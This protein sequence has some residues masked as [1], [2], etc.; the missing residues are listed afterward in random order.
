MGSSNKIKIL[1]FLFTL[2]LIVLMFPKG[3][4]L[5]S[6]VAIGSIW[7]KPDLIASKSFEIL[8][9]PKVYEAQKQ[10]AAA[11]VYP[12]FVK[13]KDARKKCL[14]NLDN[15]FETLKTLVAVTKDSSD[16][17]R[18][19]VSRNTF[20]FL[21]KLSKNHTLLSDKK[22]TFPKFKSYVKQMLSSVCRKGILNL[23]YSQ[24]RYDTISIRDDKFLTDYP[25]DNFFDMNQAKTY[26]L[27]RFDKVFSSDSLAAKAAAEI[28][29]K[30]LTPTLRYS[31]IYTS[32]ARQAAM[33]KVPRNL[34]IVNENERIVAKH[35]RITREIKLKIDSYKRY[36]GEEVTLLD[37]FLEY[38]G[39]TLHVA[40]IL[41]LYILYLYLSRKR[42]YENNKYLLLIAIIILVT[43][44]TAYLIQ[45]INVTAPI[46]YLVLVPLGSMLLAILF[47]SRVAFFGTVAIAMLVGGLRGNDYIL[48]LS[49]IAAGGLA[50]YSVRSIRNR[51][52]I[53]RTF[54]YILFGYLAAIFAFGFER[55]LDIREILIEATFASTNALISP[56]FAYGFLYLFEKLFKMSTDLT[57]LELS[58]FNNLLLRELAQKAPGTFNHSLIIGTMVEEASNLIGG[59]SIL[60]R[61]GAYYHDIG[62]VYYPEAFVENQT[63]G[64]NIHENLPPEK[65][66][67][68]IIEHVDKGIELAKENGLP[69][70]II[71]FIPMHHGT[72][73]VSYFY[74]KAKKLYGEENV[75]EE[76]YRYKGPK[77][78][79]KET[80]LLM[81]ADACESAARAMI[82]ETQE[83]L[84]NLVANII[85]ERLEDGQLDETNL[86]FRD[87]K[88]IRSAFVKVLINQSHKRIRYPHQDKMENMNVA[89]AE[90]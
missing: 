67:Q 21:K 4:S 5:D 83:K 3:E 71:D 11:K 37:T 26:L 75:K 65:S 6:E 9:D 80:G 23:S 35:D 1:I 56:V 70:E 54:F 76:D 81:L 47:D 61:V 44:F 63:K 66:A 59:N 88:L 74:E 87:L 50:A 69:E 17:Y 77:P 72:L 22:L 41:V 46:D 85:R 32:R 34:G 43:S 8:K 84:E 57:F 86:N 33:D 16:K 2:I 12:I 58:D 52:H 68:I 36:K 90:N 38:I 51:S 79:T 60:A 10:R 19:Y 78:N 64:E 31:E 7:T 62:K 89:E 53:F 25:I 55:F 27:Q 28:A 20:S 39:K 40:I 49:H 48:T 24:I 29:F 30:I 42:I 18:E 14:K 13:E 45:F 15:F 82:D 73:L